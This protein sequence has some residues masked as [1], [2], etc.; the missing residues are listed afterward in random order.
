MK[1]SCVLLLTSILALTL[2]TSCKEKGCTDAKALNKDYNADVNDGSCI[3]SNVVFYASA[4]FFNGIPITKIDIT[5][6]GNNIGTI[7]GTFYPSG[8][9]NCSAQGTVSY[10]F[11]NGSGVDWNSTVYL[12]SGATLFGSGQLSPS[13]V[14]DCIKVNVTR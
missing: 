9:G 11:L 14:S 13:S 7:P 5:I 1:K 8:P 12:A 3:Y 6:N 10:R 4:G 2:L